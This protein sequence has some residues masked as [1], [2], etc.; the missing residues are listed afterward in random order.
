MAIAGSRNPVRDRF[1]TSLAWLVAILM[2]FPIFWLGLSSI[3]TEDAATSSIPEIFPTFNQDY[4]RDRD[5]RIADGE[6]VSTW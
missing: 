1:L 6:E 3:K 4:I 5:Q 2:F